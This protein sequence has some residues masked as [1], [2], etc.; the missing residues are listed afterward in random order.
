MQ[1][2]PINYDCLSGVLATLMV[3][4]ASVSFVA[5]WRL[6]EPHLKEHEIEATKAVA[7]GGTMGT[8]LLAI[9]FALSVWFGG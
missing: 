5:M 4:C 6:N 8:V 9:L 2:Y 3:F 1:P 7:Q